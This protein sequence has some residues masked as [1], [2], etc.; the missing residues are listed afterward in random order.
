GAELRGA[1]VL[2]AITESGLRSKVERGENAG[3]TLRHGPIV[4]MLRKIGDIKDNT[5]TAQAA[6]P[7]LRGWRQEALRAVVLVEAPATG[8][9]GGPAA[10]SPAS[11]EQSPPPAP[12]ALQKQ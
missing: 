5:F 7:S 3:Q 4:R 1:A 11:A 2:L 8:R 9:I 10:P 6:L 12:R